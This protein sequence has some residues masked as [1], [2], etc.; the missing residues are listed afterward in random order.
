MREISRYHPYKLEFAQ[1]RLDIRTADARRVSKLS[2]AITPA[3][4]TASAK[5]VRKSRKWR[6]APKNN[7]MGK[8]FVRPGLFQN[9]WKN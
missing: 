4:S 7:A 3:R 8:R 6:S 2:L 5:P 9:F 1:C